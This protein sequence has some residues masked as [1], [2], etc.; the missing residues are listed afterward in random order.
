MKTKLL[1]L[2]VSLLLVACSN[3]NRTESISKEESQTSSQE[4]P[5]EDNTSS[6]SSSDE[7][8]S[9][10]PAEEFTFKAQFYSVN[11]SGAVT[12]DSK[13][14]SFTS[15]VQS[16]FMNGDTS[17][18]T[19]ASAPS[20]YAQLNYIG[21]KGQEGRFSTMI[22]GSQNQT[23]SLKLDFNCHIIKVKV[24]AQGYCKYIAYN[25]TWNVDSDC[26]LSLEGQETVLNLPTTDGQS[27]EVKTQEY[28]FNEYVDTL[29]FSTGDGRVFLNS[30]EI[31]YMIF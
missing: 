22:L 3:A 19:N 7:G 1:L 31:T 4:S 8:Q 23:G 24:E 11:D 5:I 28:I 20:G 2:A 14:A 26:S 12:G 30:I 27:S 6:E 10:E 25:D 9:S 15:F 18:I 29:N 13:S 16:Y 21:N 17:L